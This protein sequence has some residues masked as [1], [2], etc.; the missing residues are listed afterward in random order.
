MKLGCSIV[1]VNYKSAAYL[2]ECLTSLDQSSVPVE[3][4]IVDNSGELN[5]KK[6]S[7]RWPLSI[8]S[9][10]GNVGF[11]KGCNLGA[12]QSSAEYLLFLNPDTQLEPATVKALLDEAAAHPDTGAVGCRVTFPDGTAQP[13]AHKRFPGLLVHLFNYAPLLHIAVTRWWPKFGPTF[14][15]AADYSKHLQPK[16]LLGAVMLIP[17]G[18][19]D[20][21]GGFDEHFFLYREETDLCRRILKNGFK[22]Y[23]TPSA[24][25][26]HAGGASTGND[27]FSELDA[28]YSQSVYY[29][30]RKHYG[31][32]YTF[33]TWLVAVVGLAVSWLG[34]EGVRLLKLMRGKRPGMSVDTQAKIRRCLAWHFRH[35][36]GANT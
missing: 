7:S 22:I 3:L 4:I 24:H 28:R 2:A 33:I 11:G 27:A 26:V 5:D 14:Y 34:L 9:G 18:V 30:Q 23:Y 1:I 16:H 17:K 35:F 20:A 36:A 6:P 25:I 13:S 21:V 29:Y 15:A 10:Q 31:V 32:V 8:V 19:F 12:S